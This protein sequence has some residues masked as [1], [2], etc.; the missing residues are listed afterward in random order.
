MRLKKKYRIGIV[1]IVAILILFML[2]PRNDIENFS[3][4]YKNAGDLENDVEGIGRENTYQKYLQEYASE[5]KPQN[6]IAIDIGNYVDSKGV[7][8]LTEYEGEKGV[9]RASEDSYMK[10]QVDVPEAG[11]YQIYMEYYSVRSRGV[12]I[13]RK[14][15]INDEIPFIGADALRFSRCFADKNEV[16]RDNQGN[17]IRPAQVDVPS[18]MEAYFKDDRGYYTEP[19]EFYF[20]KGTNTIA[21]EAVNEPIVIK[22]LSLNAIK[23]SVSYTDYRKSTPECSTSKEAASY[24]GK[25]QGESSTLRSSPSLY[26]TYDRSSPNTE[27]YSVSDVRLNMCGGTAWRVPGQW[28]EWEFEVPENGYYNITIKGRQNYQRGFVSNRAVYI[29]GAIPFSEMGDTQF[30]YSNEWEQVTLSDNDEKPYE[31]YLEKGKHT[32][33]ME[34]SLGELGDILNR[35]EDSVYRLNEIYRKILVLTGTTPDKYRDYKIDKVYPEVIKGM[36][37]ESKRLYKIVDDTVAYAGQKA[38]QVATV[39]TLARQLEK[40]VKNPDKIPA[41]LTNY[42]DNI[43]AMGTSILTMS[44]APLDVDYITITGLDAK[45]D[46]EN[47]SFWA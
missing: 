40:F 8:A 18:W 35:M 1:F 20:K 4:K 21:L 17:D 5:G 3:N 23:E 27:P 31:F 33:R 30:R 36:D 22:S 2:I 39:Q 6:D 13:E 9:V 41:T 15:Y 12:D 26:A 28:I 11:M 43:S 32:I 7:E 29:D 46:K 14:L 10:W 19:Y 24:K 44:E 37:L 47:E 38:G 34:V 42:K 25:I 45:P 16:K